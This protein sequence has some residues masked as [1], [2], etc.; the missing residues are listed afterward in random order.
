MIHSSRH[1]EPVMAKANICPIVVQSHLMGNS[2]FYSAID[3]GTNPF[4]SK[5]FV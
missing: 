4:M 5:S 2:S 1:A 3:E